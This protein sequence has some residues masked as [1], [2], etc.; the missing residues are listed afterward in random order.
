V[1][2]QF[3]N[4]FSNGACL[5]T[6][7]EKYN[8]L[9]GTYEVAE[10]YIGDIYG[11][12]E[13]GLLR[14][15][16]DYSYGI[17]DGISSMSLKGDI[18]GCKYQDILGIRTRYLD[19]NAFN[20]CLNEY[21]S[22]TSLSDL[23]SI[24]LTKSVAEDVNGHSI[25]FDY[26]YNNDFRP[27]IS[28]TYEISFEYSLDNDTINGS[29]NASVSSK[30]AYSTTK[31]PEILSLASSVNL[32]SIILPAF[33]VYVANVAPHLMGFPLNPKATSTSRS[34]NELASTL[35][36]SATFSN[37]SIAPFGLDS[38]NES[39]SITPPLRKYAASPIL[40]GVG[41]YYIFDLGFKSRGSA[42]ISVDGI[43][44]DSQTS[45][46]TLLILKNTV[47]GLQAAYLRGKKLVLDAQ[48]YITG[49]ASFGKQQ[50]VSASF[51]SDGDEFSL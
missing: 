6:I 12:V 49:N 37:A 45:S 27:K 15:T 32:Y 33:D 46:D 18:K 7:Q 23:N 13:N 41:E 5:Q 35:S 24:E 30:S 47:Q 34:E 31:W 44:S 2:P 3:I 50:S 11:P 8:R 38:I 19:F 9:A 26:S 21:R 4:G 43:G 39:V 20:E 16:T 14:Y 29:I 22:I 42:V 10:T 17:Q 36:L 28:I 51:S 40:D 25:S 1:T 48:N